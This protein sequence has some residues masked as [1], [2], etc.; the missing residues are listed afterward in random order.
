MFQGKV[1]Q[2]CFKGRRNKIILCILQGFNFTF[3]MFLSLRQQEN[4]LVTVPSNGMSVINISHVSESKTFFPFCVCC[5][6]LCKILNWILYLRT[7][8]FSNFIL[9]L[10]LQTWSGNKCHH[11]QIPFQKTSFPLPSSERKY[12]VTR[13]CPWLQDNVECAASWSQ[14]QNPLGWKRNSRTLSP[15]TLSRCKM[16]FL[17]ETAWEKAPFPSRW[18]QNP[19]F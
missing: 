19:Q 16:T 3:L 18:F 6:N 7:S 13:A 14:S 5:S 10:L 11:S 1:I 9:V 12:E 2:D 15:T 8:I 17:G 4:A